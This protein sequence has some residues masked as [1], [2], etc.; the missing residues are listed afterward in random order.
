MKSGA[1]N[2]RVI[3]VEHRRDEGRIT[4]K[5]NLRLMSR[6]NQIAVKSSGV[7]ISRNF[8]ASRFEWKQEGRRKKIVAG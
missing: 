2:I 8:R 5:T 1:I 7:K 3:R 4:V 6:Y